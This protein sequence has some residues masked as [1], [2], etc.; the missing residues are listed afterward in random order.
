MKKGIVAIDLGGTTIKCALLSSLGELIEKWEI[1]TNK[2]D[3]GGHIVQDIALT[4]EEALHRHRWDKQ[5]VLGIGVG[6]PGAVDKEKGLVLG[7]VNLGWKGDLPLQIEL[8]KATGLRVE[9][10]N[11]ANCAALGEKWKGAG[12]GEPNLVCVT[13]GTGVGGGVIAN[14]RIVHGA[15]GAAGE[16]GHMTMIPMGGAPCNCGKT[17][18]LETIASATGIVRIAQ[19]KRAKAVKVESLSPFVMDLSEHDMTSQLVFQY[20]Q[21]QD[22]VALE[23]V[24]EVSEVLGLALSYIANTLNPT[25]IV[26]GGGVSKA[27]NTLMYPVKT[28]FQKFAYPNVARTTDLV[29]A[30]LGNDAGVYGAGYLLLE[31]SGA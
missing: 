30:Q 15:G 4:V 20:A 9:I 25:K 14:D 29:F 18:C 6:A 17:G 19:E 24:Q 16:I 10:D 23:V 28:A 1:P 26:I 31:N 8:E 7:A 13:L 2:S 21:Q 12:D 5:D 3:G 11:D 22:D 27:G